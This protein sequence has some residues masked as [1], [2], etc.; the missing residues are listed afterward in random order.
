V[1]IDYKGDTIIIYLKD[2]IKDDLESL[3]YTVSNKIYKYFNIDL[4]GFYNVNIYIDNNYGTILEYM[5]DARD[6]YFSKLE[7]NIKKVNTN[8]IY[9]I[10]DILYP[11]LKELYLYDNK[12]FIDDYISDMEIVNII[13]KNIGNIKKCAKKI[14][15]CKE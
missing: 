6:L 9:E 5:N 15:F 14:S 4:K 2:V 7:L 11:S 12:Y 1:R 3:A 10:E 13:Y 8:F